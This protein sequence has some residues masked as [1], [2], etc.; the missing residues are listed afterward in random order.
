MPI[1]DYRKQVQAE[2]RAAAVEG[3]IKTFLEQGYERA[4]LQEIARAAG[5]STGTLFKYFPSKAALFGAIMEQ[6]WEMNADVKKP[7]PTVGQPEA[8]LLSIGRDYARLLRQP[9]TTSLFRVII[10]E[11][12][13][14]PELGRMLFEYGKTP[15]INRLYTYLSEE[16]EAGT[17]QINDIPLAARQFLGMI[18]DLLFWP[19][20]LLIDFVVSDEETQR[21]VQEAVTTILARYAHLPTN[22]EPQI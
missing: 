19:G 10:A 7:L 22:L 9:I 11:A 3:A 15:Y 5:I 18:N 17:L 8:G 16:V 6:M 21:I 13:R 1:E 4:T 2:K 20:L 12:P 14:F